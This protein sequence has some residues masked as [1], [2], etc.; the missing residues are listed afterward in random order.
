MSAFVE[1]LQTSDTSVKKIHRLLKK[2]TSKLQTAVG[3][4]FGSLSFCIDANYEGDAE[5]IEVQDVEFEYLNVVGIGEDEVSLGFRAS[6]SFSAFVS[7]DDLETASYD[8]EDQ[9][10]I[11]WRTIEG[12]FMIAGT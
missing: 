12:R 5:D 4:R 6:V 3:D 1:V 11:P 9:Q 7:Y 8:N 2:D 10:L